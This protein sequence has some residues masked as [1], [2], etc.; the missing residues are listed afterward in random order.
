MLVRAK[1]VFDGGPGGDHILPLGCIALLG[2]LTIKVLQFPS[3]QTEY[4]T[5]CCSQEI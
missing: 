4:M 5:T 1:S 2:H 3:G